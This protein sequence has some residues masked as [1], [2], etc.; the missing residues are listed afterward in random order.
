MRNY[1]GHVCLLICTLLFFSVSNSWGQSI[2]TGGIAGGVT[3]ATG[4][5]V[6]D[7]KL[8]LKSSGTG[9]TF[10]YISS[11]GGEYVFSLLKPGEYIL[12]VTK[13]GFKTSTRPVT[14]VLG[15]TVTV[16][17]PLEVGSASTTVEVS[18]E[19]A[20][21]QTENANISTNF[22]TKQIQEIPNPGGDVTYIAQTAPGVTMS[23]AAGGG[24]G[25]F[26]TF[27]LPGTSNL[28]TIN[29]NDYNDPFLNLN[30]TGSSNL[31]LGGNELQEVS[32]VNNAY[33][34]EYGRQ[35]A[36]Q[37]DYTTKSGSNSFHGNAVYDWTGRYL[38]ANDPLL[39]AAGQPRPFE[40][41]NQWAASFGGPVIKDKLF[42]FVNTEGIRY[43]FGAVKTV[44]TPTP[45]FENFTLGNIAGK[46]APTIAFYQNLFKLWNAAPGIGAAVP[47]AK[48]CSGNGVPA[49]GLL[50]TDLCTQSWTDSSPSGNKEWLL[51]ARIDYSFN[52]NNK[53]F[54]RMKFDR[55]TQPTYTD[56][57]SPTFDTFSTQPQN[58][59]QLNYT[60]VF[61]PTVVNNFIG[62]VLWYSAIFGAITPSSPALALIP[63]NLVLSDGSL[64]N[65][66][67]GS[68]SGGY[69][70][71]FLFP[72]GRNVTQWGLVD[73]LSVNRGNHSFKMG[74]NWRRDDI[75]DFT[76][77]ETAVYPAVN[78]TLLGLSNDLLT[79]SGNFTNYN[80]ARS[81]VQP[82]AFYSFGLYFQD[83]YRVTPKLKMT[84]ALR[85]DRNSG[86]VCQH[87]CASLP[88]VPFNQLTHGPTVPYD[89]S[90]QT[91]LKTIIPS[92][93]LVAFQ[94]R[95]GLAWSPW[96]DKT[97]IRAGVGLF[98]DL[99]PG[100]IL[101]PIDTNF[102]QVNLWNI[103]GG[104]LA[105]DL[106]PPTTT[107][108]PGSGVSVVQTCNSI[109][110]SNYFAGGN[111]NTYLAA[112]PFCT[113]TGLPAG[114]IVNGSPSLQSVPTLND[115]SRSLQ[116]PKY[117]EW[118]LEV[119]RMLTP[120]TIFKVSYVGN[121]GFSELYY[122]NYLNGFAGAGQFGFGV[123]P[124]TPPDLR[125]G[126]VNFLQSGAVSNY[127]GMIISIEEHNWH[128]LSG[129]FNYSFS[130]AFDE[131]SN[132]GVLPWSIFSSVL[133]QINPLTIRSNYA[134]SD[135]DAR[136]QLSAS[137]IYELPF[138]STNRL[139]S[140][141]IAGWQVSGTF[142]YRTGFPFSVVD[143]GTSAGL[144][145]QNLGG[146]TNP[147]PT[148]IL[149]PL[150]TRRNFSDGGACVAAPCFGVQGVSNPAAPYQFAFPTSFTNPVVG[151]NAFTGP[152][153]LDGDISLRKN[154]R[155]NERFVFQLGLNAYNW[156][157]HANYG[158]PYSQTNFGPSNFGRTIF[159][160]APPTSPYGAFASAA[161]DMRIAQIT[162]KLNF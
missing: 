120:H 26:S 53:V 94:P 17:V 127:N 28:F 63:G 84:L 108:F 162:A 80:F 131:S 86:G 156:F 140:T 117:V 112:A 62:S 11:A 134:S 157:N 136:H 9:E 65:L 46:G 14:V 73:D 158:T 142:F 129:R 91:N 130:H 105:W 141:A 10:T 88:I 77:S 90:F 144:T 32:V 154:F 38:N 18:V 1:L 29:G 41:N 12:S 97:V 155:I 82:V 25:N 99:Y 78:A 161:T 121:R 16:N 60:H 116:N 76:A 5:V 8:T 137:Y 145:S 87:N 24:Y 7:A 3:D 135:Y 85:A 6:G 57:I 98:A 36:S 92:N 159:T 107:A 149:Q 59:G 106:K 66:G 132:G 15:T 147:G 101:S 95:F 124:L 75:S 52:D 54:G 70:N 47:N 68:G 64:T 81:P 103:A 111:Y 37:I 104:G 19:Q 152:G 45:A 30:N 55:G 122:D 138:K 109:F 119:Q 61:S 143:S 118:N 148:I 151:R 160:S 13:D 153:F 39:N 125:V 114:T 48:S 139:L 69:A 33:T 123:L 113:N 93:E 2:V 34:G 72:Q 56:T 35:A 74:V 67:F 146:T 51:S 21:L 50:A 100:T 150:F 128:G 23:S 42:F 83:E 31:L 43:I 49:T 22:E 71:G 79:G 44:T 20:Q 89:Q 110:T 4:A 40:N 126:R 27:G 58:E 96:G 115:V 133:A 102:P